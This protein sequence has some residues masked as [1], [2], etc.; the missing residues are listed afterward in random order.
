MS[1]NPGLYVVA[2]GMLAG[3]KVNFYFVNG[4]GNADCRF[5]E[6]FGLHKAG[7]IVVV[8]LKELL[9]VGEDYA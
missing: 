9:P 7:E 2:S 6:D 4:S 8:K 1:L 3:A 5:A